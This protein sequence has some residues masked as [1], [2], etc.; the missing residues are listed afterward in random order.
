MKTLH[1][2][3]KDSLHESQIDE[4]I[5]SSNNLGLP[6]EL[7]NVPKALDLLHDIVTKDYKVKKFVITDEYDD[8]IAIG[9]N[10]KDFNYIDF[11]AKYS[12]RISDILG[13][14][15]KFNFHVLHDYPQWY[16]PNK[17]FLYIHRHS[18][19]EIH[20]VWSKPFNSK[21]DD[22]AIKRYIKKL[23]S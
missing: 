12:K 17:Y 3:I 18:P 8:K 21:D 11:A 1:E 6:E 22:S 20:I 7:R 10:G 14:D 5:L 9:F 4:S 23:F 19:N 16:I 2:S 13:N 15:F